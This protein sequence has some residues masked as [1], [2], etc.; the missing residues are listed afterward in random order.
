MVRFLVFDLDETLYPAQA[1]LFREIGRRIN[2][3]LQERLGIPLEEAL[4]LRQ[5]YY[6]RYG[7]TLRGL[8]IHHQVDPEDYL[9][10]VHDVD[11][12]AY[13]QPDPALEAVLSTLSQEKV[14]FTNATT[15]HAR[16]VLHA[17]GLAHHFPRIFDIHS[18]RFH[19]KPD[20]EAY[21]ILLKLLPAEGQECL[22]IEDNMRN[23]LAGKSFGM[24]TFLVGDPAGHQDGVDFQGSLLQLPEAVRSLDC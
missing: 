18:L 17:L 9:S 6:E 19:C 7:T 20:P 22:L 5:S 1:G 14:I 16:Q 13:L 24:H 12:S 8:Q 10:F 23:L 11:V 2:L 4:P 21:R 15:A 3:Y